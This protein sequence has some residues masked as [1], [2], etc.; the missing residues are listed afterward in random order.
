MQLNDS[1]G[2]EDRER[3]PPVAA[4]VRELYLYSGNQCAFP[5]CT[6]LLLLSN[7]TWNCEVAH[8]RGVQ[9]S[10]ARGEHDLTNEELRAPW[11]LIL[12]CLNHH[13]EI[14]NIALVS[15]YSITAVTDMKSQH[16]A[17][18][19]HAIGGL[20]RMVEAT[21][22]VAPRYPTNLLALGIPSDETLSENLRGVRQF[23]DELAKVPVA[24]R[25]VIAMILKFGEQ[26]QGLSSKFRAPVSIAAKV[27][28]GWGQL[29]EEEVHE[30]VAHLER[31][32]LVEVIDDDGIWVYVL[33]S[34][35]DRE[36]GWDIYPDISDLA[37]GDSSTL[38]RIIIDLDF[39]PFGA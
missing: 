33:T 31:A 5:G 1:G 8:I 38:N 30:R 22:G 20:E 24:F 32:G 6:Q 18:Y 28:A 19:R 34:I 29:R 2:R 27:L 15:L 23:V 4:T 13:N 12:L 25:D 14:D 16:E 7:G 39:T 10:A 3:L 21:S 26:R 17:R 11:N 36:L 35:L 37:N 9:R